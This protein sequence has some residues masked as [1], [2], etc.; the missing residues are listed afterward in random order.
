VTN[1]TQLL[2]MLRSIKLNYLKVEARM[3]RQLK[4]GISARETEYT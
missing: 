4:R 3:Q 1:P 2:K